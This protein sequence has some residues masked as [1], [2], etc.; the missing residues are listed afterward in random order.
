MPE[1][2]Q[3]SVPLLQERQA[4]R[5]PLRVCH[6][7]LGLA[8]GGLERLLVD[9]AKFHHRDQCE[10]TFLALHAAGRPADEIRDCGCEVRALNSH[11]QGRLA[12]WKQLA[13]LF[14]E[15]QP[16]VVHTHNAAP[17]WYATPAAR[18]A[19]VPIVVNTR[20]GQRFGQTWRSQWQYR[21]AARMVD[22]IVAVS[23]DAAALCLR[24][25]KL[26]AEKVITIWNGIDLDRFQ[27]RGPVTR[28]ELI[29]VARLS[30]EKDF[31]T[32]LR[33]V[34]LARQHIPELRLR[35]IG[36]GAERPGLEK[37]AVSW[38][39][40]GH[41]EFLGERSN[42][43]ELLASAGCFVSSS[44]TEGISLTLLEAMAVGL[45]VLATSVG[46]NPEIVVEGETGRL[47]PA[48]DP[49]A[50][51]AGIVRMWQERAQWESY[52]R[53]GRTRIANHFDIRRMV[54]Q[55]E[56]LYA[57]LCLTKVRHASDFR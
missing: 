35:I 55:Y 8:T 45:P 50:F 19:G 13:R 11:G 48:A 12:V 29:S 53:Q 46:G 2:L 44:L 3:S 27:Y 49:A 32:L 23:E 10:M 24:E 42:V 5:R 40:G 21:L 54:Q 30:A 34:D 7:S 15:L 9:F 14:R 22:R 28:P 20:H 17:H 26:P 41:V 56:D 57:A 1:T 4:M 18:W 39:L 16:D 37:L 43:P 31:P 51:A 52:G 25:D 33:A 6:V 38:Q 47:V 36:D